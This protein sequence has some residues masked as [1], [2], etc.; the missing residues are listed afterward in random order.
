MSLQEPDDNF[1]KHITM[2]QMYPSENYYYTISIIHVTGNIFK[3]L[4]SL[5][6]LG[7]CVT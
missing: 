5:S 3:F 2:L 4:L 1:S 6:G 7:L